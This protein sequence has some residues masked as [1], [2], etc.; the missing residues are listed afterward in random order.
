MRIA[1]DAMGGDNAPK[2]VVEGAIKAAKEFGDLTVVLYGDEQQI[3]DSITED[4]NNIEIVH[5]SEKIEG[6]D[7]PVR[8]V[9]RK[10]DSS[11]VVAAKAV[12]N[13]T[14]NALVSAGNTGA[15]L[16]AGTLIV[17]RIKGIERPALM[18]ILPAVG[19]EK[20]SFNFLD[21]GANADSK[22]KNLEQ[23][24]VLASYYAEKI[25]G[26]T[27]PTVALLN[28]GTEEN[29]GNELTK[30]T[31]DLLKENGAINFIGNVEARELLEGP[32]NVIVTDGFTGNA[33][34]KTLEGTVKTILS[35][36][37]STI[38]EGK[39]TT[40]FGGLL[41]KKDLSKLK[42]VLDYSQHG[43][44]VLIGTKAPVVKTHGSADAEAIYSTI[45]QTRTMVQS[46]MIEELVDYF[47]ND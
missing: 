37:K 24:A 2:I 43:G 10:K 16:T 36:I 8:A 21:L 17:G 32:A 27:N 34:L 40:K 47:E 5:T 6:T 31:H 11:M 23:F 4:L 33:V 13:G 19:G 30:S 1:I 20:E 29:K 22:P 3:K 38:K 9:R 14:D 41:I 7:E 46:N 42:N 12:K 26:I 39:T 35:L 18:A 25:Q 15:L 28:N 44:A 45:R